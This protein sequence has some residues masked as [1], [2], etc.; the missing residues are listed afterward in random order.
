MKYALRCWC[1]VDASM[2]EV[3]IVN[4]SLEDVRLIFRRRRAYLTLRAR[5]NSLDEMRFWNVQARFYDRLPVD[6][7]A[8]ADLDDVCPA[9]KPILDCDKEL[10]T[11]AD[12]EA[13]AVDPYEARTDG[14]RLCLDDRGVWWTCYPKHCDDP[15]FT[16]LIPYEEL[17][18]LL[19]E[20]ANGR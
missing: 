15:L 1:S 10:I 8:A 20:P 12:D 3:A 19:E 9:I 13:S 18:P 14:D 4:L 16:A 17:E 5:D 2:P 11:L 6:G 7:P